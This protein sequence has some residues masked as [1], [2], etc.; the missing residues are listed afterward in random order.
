MNWADVKHFTRR[1]FEPWADQID[2]HLVACLDKYRASRPPG[3][4]GRV[5]I[6]TAPGA[7]GRHGGALSSSQH[8]VDR[9]PTVRAA[10]VFPAGLGDDAEA[11]AVEYALARAA[12]FTGIGI[13]PDWA[14]HPGL[15]LDVRRDRRAGE[16]ATWAGVRRNGKQ[17]YIPLADIMPAGWFA[18]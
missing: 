8:N 15:H 9:W 16:P 4:A 3:R 2:P 6:S 1:E 10:D 5:S 7:L 14:P 12:G 13:Y 17:V 18:F 11:F